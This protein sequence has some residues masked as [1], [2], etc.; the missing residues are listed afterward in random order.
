VGEQDRSIGHPGTLR[1]SWLSA[2]IAAAA[3]LACVSC[4]HG[5]DVKPWQVRRPAQ[6]APS[7]LELRFVLDQEEPGA[8]KLPG[9][10]GKPQTLAAKPLAVG[11]DVAKVEV[12]RD[13]VQASLEQKREQQQDDTP[14]VMP[15]D[16]PSVRPRMPPHYV[17]LVTFAPAAA[18]RLWQATQEKYGHRVAIVVDGR[19]LMTPILE[20]GLP[21]NVPMMIQGSFTRE[22]AIRLAERLAP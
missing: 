20:S 12:E 4:G 6:A 7:S 21:A 2:A 13:L 15:H 17:V 8:L 18:Q 5:E 9:P 3:L 22:A 10:D 16:K 1:A 11:T 19:I 14:S